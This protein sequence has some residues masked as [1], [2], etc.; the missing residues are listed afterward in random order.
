MTAP[1]A[2]T[3][4]PGPPRPAVKGDR[5]PP[6]CVERPFDLDDIVLGQPVDLDEFRLSLRV[7]AAVCDG[8][9]IDVADSNDVVARSERASPN[10][11][12]CTPPGS[13][14]L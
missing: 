2:R 7:H 13:V 10:T 9:Q 4:R 11:W 6:G 3:S 12:P 1:L 5:L 8:D 14:R